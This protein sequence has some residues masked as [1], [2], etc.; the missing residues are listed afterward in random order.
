MTKKELLNTY[1]AKVIELEELRHQ[2][3]RVG[4]DGRPTGCRTQQYDSIGRGTNDPGA[5]SMQLSEG[6]EALVER[7]EAELRK[8]HPLMETLLKEI[9]DARTYMVVQH[10]YMFARTDEEIG[11]TLAISRTRTNQI[12][13]I[14]MKAI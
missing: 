7:K 8:L 6:L 2:L 11:Y 9:P 12:R 14:Y 1:R 3:R 4:T 13:R 5:A 10:Y